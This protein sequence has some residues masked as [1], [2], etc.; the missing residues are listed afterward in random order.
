MENNKKT[1]GFTLIELMIV[2]AIIGIL[3]A[4][5]VQKYG[6]MLRRTRESNAKGTL[7]SLRS[8]LSIYYSDNEG[9]YP[10]AAAG[11]NQSLLV[12]A[13]VPKYVKEIPIIQVYPY[14]VPTD[15]VDTTNDSDFVAA[16]GSDDGEWVY[17]SNHLDRDWG[18]AAIECYHTDSKGTTWTSY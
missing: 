15:T 1:R 14:H 18:M 12:D 4:I 17:V 6:D 2:V 3:A 8:A 5:A 7:G 11:D 16:D 10:A 13:L 9:W